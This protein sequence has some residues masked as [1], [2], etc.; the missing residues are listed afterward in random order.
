MSAPQWP[1]VRP[2]QPITAELWNLA[3][4]FVRANQLRAGDGVRLRWTPDGTIISAPQTSADFD[5]PF[6]VTLVGNAA[7]ITPGTIN[8]L[9]VFIEGV[10]LD[11][12]PPPHL[13]WS[14]LDVD[15]EGRGFIAVEFAC[16]KD[17]KV[18]PETLT[19]VQVAD[20]GSEDGRR[21]KDQGVAQEAPSLNDRRTRWPL[22][23][24][25]Q[26][27]GKQIDV[28][29]ITMAPLQHRAVPRADTNAARHFFW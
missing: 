20:W 22:A 8:S 5:H 6:C 3:R 23:M 4:A 16:D 9:P 17:W 29:Q 12:E 27:A 28:F 11:D 1:V 21:A 19:V 14:K 7:R 10:P 25:R 26:R 2:G 15:D 24:L 13:E 18:D